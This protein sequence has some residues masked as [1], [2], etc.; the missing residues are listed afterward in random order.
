MYPLDVIRKEIQKLY[1][2]NPNIHVNITMKHPKIYLH[3][4][5]AVIKGVY[6]HIFQIEEHSSGCAQTH[7]LQYADVLM[8]SVEIRELGEK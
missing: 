8:H 4:E 1:Q 7:S 5:P 3:N 6:P 2:T